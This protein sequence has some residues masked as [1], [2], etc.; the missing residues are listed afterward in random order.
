MAYSEPA[1]RVRYGYK[2]AL[3]RPA[4]PIEV[5]DGLKYL[6]KARLALDDSGLPQERMPR[7]ALA[8]YLHALLASD[9]FFFVD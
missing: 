7:A 5:T 9:E 2:L 8:S 6:E 4:T 3:G 1:A